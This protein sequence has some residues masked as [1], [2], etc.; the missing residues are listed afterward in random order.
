MAENVSFIQGN[1]EQYNPSE[2]QGGLFFS[3]DS[4]E[5]L[6]NGES[7]G[8]AI[9][10]DEED[11][12]AEEGNLKLKDR[13]YDEANFSGKGYV[14]LRKN[15]QEVTIP[16]FDLTIING[17]TADGNITI[18]TII[19]AVTTQDNTPELIAQKIQS[20]VT[21]TTIDGATITF[22]S[23][24]TIDY[25]DTGVIGNIVDNSYQTNKNILTQD[26][27]NQPDTIYEVRY[28]Y[29]IRSTLYMR[30]RSC[31]VYNGGTVVSIEN[32]YRIIPASDTVLNTKICNPFTGDYAYSGNVII[33]DS[34]TELRGSRNDIITQKADLILNQPIRGNHSLNGF[35]TTSIYGPARF[36]GDAR[37]R[38]SNLFRNIYLSEFIKTNNSYNTV[39]SIP[40]LTLI[41]NKIKETFDRDPSFPKTIIVDVQEVKV[42]DTIQLD[43]TLNLICS[44]RCMLYLG[45][46]FSN[47]DQRK[48]I[49]EFSSHAIASPGIIDGF[50]LSIKTNQYINCFCELKSRGNIL[51]L[52]NIRIAY[53]HSDSEIENNRLY[54]HIFKIDTTG[55]TNG[56]P[57]P[58]SY[59]D[60]LTFYNVSGQNTSNGVD[61]IVGIGDCCSFEKCS[62]MNIFCAG[63]QKSFKECM[64]VNIN[65]IQSIITVQNNHNEHAHYSFS[66]CNVTF[67][68]CVLGDATGHNGATILLNDSSL[69]NEAKQL[70]D[71]MDNQ[72]F[73][74]FEERSSMTY[75][76][77]LN[78]L[79][80][81][82]E[83]SECN[84]FRRNLYDIESVDNNYQI[85]LENS[86]HIPSW[87]DKRYCTQVYTN[88]LLPEIIF[89][90]LNFEVPI[91]TI[92]Q[93]AQYSVFESWSSHKK[94]EQ[95]IESLP[96][97]PYSISINNILV[98]FSTDRLIGQ[99]LEINYDSKDLQQA[100]RTELACLQNTKLYPENYI[101]N[102]TINQIQKHII[103]PVIEAGK[104]TDSAL[105]SYQMLGRSYIDGSIEDYNLCSKIE[106][107]QSGKIR[108]YLEELPKYGKWQ[109]GDEVVLS[110]KPQNIY[111]FNGTEWYSDGW[112]T[113]E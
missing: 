13:T 35:Y 53:G 108:A 38:R 26:M 58:D 60:F 15:I 93:G 39:D 36:R 6:L 22:T 72:Y 23:N 84:G 8:N 67:Q 89:P 1:K 48:N 69:Y 47:S 87:L 90:E 14:I 42:T 21:G 112:A 83:V 66:Q 55:Y 50:I 41:Y 29:V 74:E 85:T 40:D 27:I 105:S 101:F 73:E 37:Y 106:L 31:L 75:L 64:H 65:A 77:C 46:S 16:K 59:C 82:N 56:N 34:P 103:L 79:F 107:L 61:V 111:K 7:Y 81:F 71:C 30:D 109:I 100:M 68:D 91:F 25:S 57:N 4:K 11:I 20:S 70:F 43:G 2:M 19:I 110:S 51:N 62:K 10:A 17:C 44:S 80:S 33:V 104:N 3:K 32:N 9:P 28:D 45:N 24:P 12:T 96:S 94:F 52:R 92:R 95:Y 63:G 86:Y 18:N 49:F 78:T 113:I 5:I 76:H 98:L 54:N 97:E 102:L 88:N 99:K